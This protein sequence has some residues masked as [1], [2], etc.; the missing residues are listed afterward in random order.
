MKEI[1]TSVIKR[2]HRIRIQDVAGLRGLHR[3]KEEIDHSRRKKAGK[4]SAWFKSRRGG[5]R[6]PTIKDS[7][8]RTEYRGR[9][10]GMRT[11]KQKG[12]IR[13]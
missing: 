1:L 3:S 8:T 9:K 10:T 12:Q 13:R 7:P 6:I 11:S 4:N 5:E 2:Y